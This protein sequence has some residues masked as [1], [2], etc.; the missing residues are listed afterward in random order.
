MNFLAWLFVIG[1]VSFVQ[2]MAFTWVSRSRN[3]GDPEYHRTAAICSNGIWFITQLLLWRQI[4]DGLVTGVWWHLVLV[5]LV[6]TLS[7]TEGSVLAMKHLLKTEQ[8]KRM[9]GAR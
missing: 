1:V 6:Y 5:G 7:T 3:S 4:W 8:G 9:V 2:T